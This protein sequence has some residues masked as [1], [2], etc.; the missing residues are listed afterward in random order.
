[1]AELVLLAH[2][3][4]DQDAIEIG[5]LYR[6]AISSAADSVKYLAEAGQR[7]I[8]KKAG[9]PRGEWLPWLEANQDLLEFKTRRTAARLM[10]AAT[11][12][13]VDVPLDEARA[14]KAN[15]AIWGNAPVRGTA[16]TGDNEWFTPPVF[17]EAAR[18]VLG[19][20]ID[21]DPASHALAPRIAERRYTRE[22]DGLAQAWRGTVWLNP[23][24]A[25]DEI[26]PF[27]DKLL[28]EIG[29]GNTT[30][31]IMLTH[32][33]TDTDWFHRAEARAALLCF[34]LGRIKF[35]DDAGDKCNPTQG[36]AFFYYGQE[37]GL[38]RDVFGRFG[39]VR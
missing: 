37:R 1:M 11:E 31:A 23:P 34:T 2:H 39:F 25:R 20:T 29:C 13:D 6:R 33:Y 17:I 9:M 14:V 28:A 26:G 7:L 15:R 5:A 10:K 12:W 30:A 35:I 24:Y 16:G 32:N 8:E 18:H 27:I 21:L 19:G 22:D 3:N 38:F 4:R 36:Q